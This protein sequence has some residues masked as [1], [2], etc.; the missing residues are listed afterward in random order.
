MFKAD[1]GEA[2]KVEIVTCLGLLTPDGLAE[3]LY[4]LKPG[5][6]VQR[7]GWECEHVD[8]KVWRCFQTARIH[9]LVDYDIND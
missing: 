1:K 9:P 5:G 4:L 2:R 3:V 6:W 8:S 7:R